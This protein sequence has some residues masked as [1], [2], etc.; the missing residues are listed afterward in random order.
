MSITVRTLKNFN[1]YRTMDTLHQ[2]G[3]YFYATGFIA[4]GIMHFVFG[5]F[6]TGRAPSWPDQLPGQQIWTW[7]TGILF[8]VTGF[9]VF[10]GKMV[11]QLALASG[12]VIILW[13]AIRHIPVVASDQLLG[14]SWTQL[15]KALI[16]SGGILAIAGSFP[17]LSGK[18]FIN[19]II[20]FEDRFIQIGQIILGLYML[21][22]GIQHFIFVDFVASLI[23]AIVPWAVFW[24][25]FGGICLIAGGLGLL[26]KP[27]QR[28][29]ALLSGI[30]IFSWVFI[31][32]IPL[33]VTNMG[34]EWI[35]VFE[36]FAISGLAF[37]LVARITWSETQSS[38][39][40]A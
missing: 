30:M 34:V 32:H 29:A 35:A 5:D 4:F 22:C 17:K 36:A 26:I 37:F 28:I 6:I 10:T 9:S 24:T 38:V 1:D 14:G 15:G 11:R 7:L 8:I 25:Y 19:S 12:I 39:I 3:R 21:L 20:N 2:Y 31:V 13:A 27:T 18:G 23:P 40:D 16:F 33:A